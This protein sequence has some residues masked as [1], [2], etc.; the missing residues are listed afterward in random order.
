[1]DQIKSNVREWLKLGIVEP[2]SSPFNSPI[3]CVPKKEGQGLRI[4]LDYRKL[5]SISLPDRY[6]LR[7]VDD[8]LAEIG[9]KHSKIFT[10][11]DLTSGFWQMGL[12]Q[13]ARPYTAFTIP[14]W[15]QFQWRRGAMGLA[16]CPASFAR[17]MDTIFAG[18]ANIVTYI[19]DILVHSANW[20]DHL[21]HLE[22]AFKTLRQHNLKMNLDK[23]SFGQEEVAYLGHT[24]TARGVKPGLDKSA[25]I[26]DTQPPTS[27]SRLRGFLGLANYFRNYIPS[28]SLLAA[29]C[30]HSPVRSRTG[31]EVHCH[32][33]LMRPSATF[34]LVSQQDQSWHFQLQ[35]ANSI[36]TLTPPEVS[37][38]AKAVSALPFANFRLEKSAS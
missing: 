21:D 33:Q 24:I 34:G 13:S 11:I 17:M 4:V 38:E 9:K 5:N 18:H 14:G 6:S 8:C 7:S 10:T 12:A 15:G 2:A 1:M 30:S 26:R 25:M 27:I 29:P 20:F 22:I 37:M 3:F 31:R 35:M 16:G 36:S 28:F 19:D 23:C 32:L